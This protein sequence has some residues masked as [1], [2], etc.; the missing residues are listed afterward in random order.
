MSTAS[1]VAVA[2]RA[3][4]SDELRPPDAGADTHRPPRTECAGYHVFARR[5]ETP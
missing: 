2:L 3:T 5:L 4:G 1:V